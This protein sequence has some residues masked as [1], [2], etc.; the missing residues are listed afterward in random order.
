MHVVPVRE[1]RDHGHGGRPV[2][3]YLCPQEAEAC[4]G[5]GDT[6]GV[7]PTTGTPPRVQAWS[8][9][10]C[11]TRWAITAV[12]PQQPAYFGDL[13]AAVE[14]LGR[15]RWTLRQIVQLADQMPELTDQQLRARLLALAETCG[16]R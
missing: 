2:T 6:T 1:G 13:C 15:L 11:D 5:C 8:C 7:Q 14:Q 12:R 4:P 16:A 10:E 3:R 9:T